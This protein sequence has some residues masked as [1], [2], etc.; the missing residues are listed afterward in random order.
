MR[1]PK[2]PTRI[3]LKKLPGS[4][5][6]CLCLWFICTAA[7]LAAQTPALRRAHAAPAV[8]RAKTVLKRAR[9]ARSSPPPAAP[10]RPGIPAAQEQEKPRHRKKDQDRDRDKHGERD[11]DQEEENE[12][13]EEAAS[14]ARREWFMFQREYPFE[15]VP[16]G[17]RRQAWEAARLSREALANTPANAILRHWRSVSPNGTNSYFPGN[18]GK[19]S[20]RV[21]ALAVSPADSNLVLAG[22][23]TG[24]IWRS[25]DGGATWAPVSDDQAD[26]AVGALAF[27]P[28]NPSVVYAAMGGVF[29]LLGV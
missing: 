19:T 25:T 6:L 16:E 1:F 29:V 7:P 27:A 3:S 14:E 28:S 10:L 11:R 17:A 24:G 2:T 13:E 20:G 4:G 15:K 12:A 21:N 26:L 22:A 9:R 8:A 23:S 5:L 18:W